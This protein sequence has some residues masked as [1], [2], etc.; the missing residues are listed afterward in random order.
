MS[1]V[2]T[3][4]EMDRLARNLKYMMKVRKIPS[5]LELAVRAKVPKSTLYRFFRG[6]VFQPSINALK[7]LGDYL[8][9]PWWALVSI[10]IETVSLDRLSM[11]AI[12]SFLKT[13][14]ADANKWKHLE[15]NRGRLDI[16]VKEVLS[17]MLT[18]PELLTDPANL[19]KVSE[20]ISDRYFASMLEDSGE[21][22]G[23]TALAF[24]ARRAQ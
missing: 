2:V 7:N 16:A 12:Q 10:E 14:D 5:E 4:E 8:E 24:H 6:E 17:Y 22:D 13:G 18:R 1:A 15:I 21:V 23:L 20:T 11:A 19:S 3:Q 9:V